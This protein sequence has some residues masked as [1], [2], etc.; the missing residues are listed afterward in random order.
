LA[1]RTGL[2]ESA[3]DISANW[4]VHWNSSDVSISLKISFDV[5]Y[6]NNI[7]INKL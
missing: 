7:L 2:I 6:K 5:D 1:L 4:K 3:V